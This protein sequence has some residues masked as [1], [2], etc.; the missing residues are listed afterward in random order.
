MQIA[1]VSG[2]ANNFGAIR[3]LTTKGIQKGHMKMHLLNIL[4]NF[5]ATETEKHAAIE[6][7]RTK[8]VSFNAVAEFV[9]DIRD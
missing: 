4:N 6:Y 9:K 7:F 2:L 1:A 8:K 3:S 5:G